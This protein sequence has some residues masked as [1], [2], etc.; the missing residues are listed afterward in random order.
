MRTQYG[1]GSKQGDYHESGNQQTLHGNLRLARNAEWRAPPQYGQR[2]QADVVCLT[3]H[4][5]VLAM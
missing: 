2:L 3:Y 4:D 5:L 1:C